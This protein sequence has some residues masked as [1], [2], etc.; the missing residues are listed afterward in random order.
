LK[1]PVEI[2][3]LASRYK[4]SWKKSG[5]RAESNGQERRLWGRRRG[6]KPEKPR[7]SDRIRVGKLVAWTK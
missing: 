5:Q 2:Q 7:V 4:A 1:G 3:E 6:G